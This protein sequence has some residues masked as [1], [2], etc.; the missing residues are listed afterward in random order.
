MEQISLQKVKSII[1]ALMYLKTR[2]K[3]FNSF[4]FVLSPVILFSSLENETFFK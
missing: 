1:L 4:K 3:K 2:S